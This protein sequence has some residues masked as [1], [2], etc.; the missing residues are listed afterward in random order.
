MQQNKG[1]NTGIW[2]TAGVHLLLAV[3]LLLIGLEYVPY[4]PDT[5]LEIEFELEEE[6]Q[7]LPLKIIAEQGSEPR[8]PQ[9][10]PERPPE[11]VQQA[12]V[13]EETPG[14]QRTGESTPAETG[15]VEVSDPE[16]P[17]I[18]ERALYRSRD[19]DTTEGEQTGLLTGEERKAGDPAG[20]TQ[21]G[22]PLGQ[23]TA[24]L[25]GR[26][27]V[28]KLPL[29][30]YSENLAGRVVVRILVD[31]YGNVT[32]ATPGIE[33]TTVQ[34]KV[35]WDAARKAALQARFNISGSAAAVQEG[36]ITYVFSLK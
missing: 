7:P 36:K 9:P 5:L 22:N 2:L 6:R 10:V 15:D 26:S 27:I 8:S 20:N 12:V 35:L 11:L 23:P 29:P 19:A 14:T 24:Q 31:T 28:G 3:V 32:S 25:A 34:N 30:E 16:P 4:L 1:K 33:G 17:V 18:N 13:P 21:A